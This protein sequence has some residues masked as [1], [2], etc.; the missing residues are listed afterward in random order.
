MTKK[1]SRKERQGIVVGVD[2]CDEK[3]CLN[4]GTTLKWG[5]RRCSECW[6]I[7]DTQS[8]VWN[9]LAP[10]VIYRRDGKDKKDCVVKLRLRLVDMILKARSKEL[11]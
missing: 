6:T 11:K 7:S 9:A 10:F 2:F 5:I 4:I 3:A 1:L 8:D